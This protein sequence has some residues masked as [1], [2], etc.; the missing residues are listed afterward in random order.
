[1]ARATGAREVCAFADA[2]PS[3]PT[4]STVIAE[5]TSLVFIMRLRLSQNGKI[6]EF[7][8]TLVRP[9]GVRPLDMQLKQ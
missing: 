6:V 1:M 7:Q 4:A 5:M 2:A 8:E 9:Q 3:M